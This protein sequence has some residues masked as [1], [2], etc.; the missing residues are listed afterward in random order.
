MGL[1]QAAVDA[2]QE[3][4]FRPATRDGEP[5]AVYYVLT[6]NFALR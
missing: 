3:Y 2:V 4:R 1:D 6:V 5:V